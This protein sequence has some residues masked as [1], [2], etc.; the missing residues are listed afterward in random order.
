MP[1][2]LFMASSWW[3]DITHVGS[4]V[5]TSVKKNKT[6]YT[7][8]IHDISDAV[9]D[10][11]DLL[12]GSS[13]MSADLTDGIPTFTTFIV[14][15]ANGMVKHY[16]DTDGDGLF[17]KKKDD[18]IIKGRAPSSFSLSNAVDEASSIL[19]DMGTTY[20]HGL[21]YIDGL[22][23]F[24][25]YIGLATDAAKDLG[26]WDSLD[27]GITTLGNAVTKTLNISVESGGTSVH[28]GASG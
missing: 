5:K 8:A 23:D 19:G 7:S 15:N 11:S 12:T 14:T 10:A 6:I 1:K 24:K 16:M 18:M 20:I 13:S 26:F 3:N 22:D 4:F 9:S 17:N 27:H 2:K 25:N 28:V 21:Q